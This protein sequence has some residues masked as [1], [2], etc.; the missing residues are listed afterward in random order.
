MARMEMAELMKEEVRSEPLLGL[1][2]GRA[3]ESRV[4][5]DHSIFGFSAFRLPPSSNASCW[6]LLGARQWLN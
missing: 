5:I 2:D 6:P 3:D 1:G 4:A